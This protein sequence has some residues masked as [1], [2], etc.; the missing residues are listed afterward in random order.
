VNEGGREAHV[1][2]PLWWSGFSNRVEVVSSTNSDESANVEHRTSNVERRMRRAEQ[3]P[4]LEANC[5]ICNA[6]HNSDNAIRRGTLKAFRS[7][8]QGCPTF[9]GQPWVGKTQY[10]RTL[11][12]QGFQCDRYLL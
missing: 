12:G 6:Q 11:K 10:D 5:D 2:P 8:A 3:A 9:V 1:R 4:R 7:T